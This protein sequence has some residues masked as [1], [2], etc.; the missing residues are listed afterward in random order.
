MK[1][2]MISYR[3][4]LDLIKEDKQPMEVKLYLYV[5]DANSKKYTWNF[6]GGCYLI[7]NDEQENEN[8]SFYLR[9]CLLDSQSF[10][11][12]IEPCVSTVEEVVF[13]LRNRLLDLAESIRD[14]TNK[15]LKEKICPLAEHDEFIKLSLLEKI[16]DMVEEYN[17][18]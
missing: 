7:S 15:L 12:L 3:E 18:E 6:D 8:Y 4:L 1:N 9:D 11:M 14:E 16:V 5:G 10:D 17:N 13:V 2:E